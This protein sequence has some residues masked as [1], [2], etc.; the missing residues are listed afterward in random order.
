MQKIRTHTLGIDNGSILL[1]SDFQDGGAM[2]TGK[3]PRELRRI[4]EF[5]ESFAAPPV[6]NVSISM[7]DIDQQ[8]NHRVDISAEMVNEE[9]FVIVFR[10]WGDTR[11]ARV[12]ADWVAFGSLKHEDEWEV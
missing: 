3:G 2:W 12:R 5:T 10:T 11:V 8:T 4:V 1:F 6:V 9:G 7:L